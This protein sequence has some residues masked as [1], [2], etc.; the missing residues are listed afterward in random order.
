VLRAPLPD[1]LP[2]AQRALF[3]SRG[4]WRDFLSILGADTRIDRNM[5]DDSWSALKRWPKQAMVKITTE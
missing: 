2:H 4:M 1:S 5:A 3:A